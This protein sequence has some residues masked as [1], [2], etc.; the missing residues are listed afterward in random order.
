M[1]LLNIKNVSMSIGS[2]DLLI[3]ICFTI[4]ARQRIALVGRN[5]AGKSTLMKII[6]G[7]VTADSGELVHQ[8]SLRVAYLQQSVPDDIQGTVYSVVAGGLPVV[9]AALVKYH[10]ATAGLAVGEDTAADMAE[11]QSVL[12]ANDG[13]RF[14]QR[15]SEVLSKVE[16][17][18]DDQFE[19][20][21]GG[22]KRRVLLAQALLQNPD[23]LLLDEPTNHLDIPSIQWLEAFLIS[24]N[25]AVLFITHD[26]SFLKK[27]ATDILEIDRGQLTHWPG[28]YAKYLQGKAEQLEVEERHNALFDK[29][30]AQEEKWIRQGIKARRTRNEGRVRA[31]KQLRNERAARV[32]P[33]K[34]VKFEVS[35]A[36]RSGKRVVEVSELGYA[37]GDNVIVQNFD[38]AIMRQDRI[39]I[40]GPNGVGK[41]TLVRLLLGELEPDTGQ[42]QLG[43]NIQ[44]AYFDQLRTALRKD[45]SAMDNVSGGK[46]MVLVNGK[47]KHIIS[48]MQ[49]F[50]F[51]P[52]RSRAP[53]TALS[54]GETNRLLLATLFLKPSN[55]LVLDEPT[56]DLDI[57]TLEL[58]EMVL[59]EYVGTV[60]LISHDRDFIDN[61]VTSTL[62]FEAPGVIHEHIGGY[63]DWHHFRQKNPFRR[64]SNTPVEKKVSAPSTIAEKGVVSKKKVKLSYKDQREYDQLPNHIEALESKITALEQQ[65]SA[66]EFYTSGQATEPTLNELSTTQLALDTAYERWAELDLLVSSSGVDSAG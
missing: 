41:T 34:Q 15:V 23:I 12:D 19:A 59:A 52:E 44:I 17:V 1:S 43:T 26:R 56:N 49:D 62:V 53:I 10:N 64:A 21:S 11:A 42:V 14:E 38:C 8:P 63:S 5:G 4:E 30:L 22:L 36:D 29:K 37:F 55:V 60:L 24:A 16:L 65:V 33:T 20:L 25:C 50:L 45:R 18:A 57:E 6:A 28:D 39:G 47:E 13:W 3:D 7:Q 27:L 51:T 66:P 2:Q 35:Q 46:D 40:V 32:D 61:V 58:L 54:G 9:G 31:L 48:Y